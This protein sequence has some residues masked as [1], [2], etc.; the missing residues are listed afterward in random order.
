MMLNVVT[1]I[2]VWGLIIY[3]FVNMFVGWANEVVLFHTQSLA[4]DKLLVPAKYYNRWYNR[5][6][7]RW[8]NIG[9][10]GWVHNTWLDV[11]YLNATIWQSVFCL[12]IGFF[13]N[14][15]NYK[16]LWCN[17]V[18]KKCLKYVEWS[19]PELGRFNVIW[20]DGL[21]I[22]TKCTCVFEDISYFK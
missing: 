3:L 15:I 17:N 9:G 6:I 22:I 20:L 4:Q 19:G 2:Y 12:S 14:Q 18:V 8:G 7:P 10:T 16:N 1:C 11:Y 5:L 13:G 21:K